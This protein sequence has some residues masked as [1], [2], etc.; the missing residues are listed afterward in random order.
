[1][2]AQYRDNLNKSRSL[3][4]NATTRQNCVSCPSSCLRNRE[5]RSSMDRLMFRAWSK[6]PS[7]DPSVFHQSSNACPSCG[8]VSDHEN[9]NEGSTGPAPFVPVMGP[10]WD[11]NVFASPVAW[12]TP[13][14]PGMPYS[15]PALK[16]A[17][18]NCTA[19]MDTSSV[20]GVKQLPRPGQ[21]FCKD[22]DIANII[23]PSKCTGIDTPAGA[24]AM[25]VGTHAAYALTCQH[26]E[27][28]YFYKCSPEGTCELD[29][30]VGG[31]AP[32]GAPN[33]NDPTCGGAAV[34]LADG[35]VL[36]RIDG[37]LAIS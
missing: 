28:P 34:G 25:G 17:A 15:I 26:Y 24:V 9:Y 13:G 32:A 6:G 21:I 8:R 19:C 33:R 35:C 11:T 18:K 3:Y 30:S 14:R 12:P 7:G 27:P 10:C 1:M 37:S 29:T 23:H 36:G 2:S 5:E 31:E 16:A 20:S 4:S 22:Q